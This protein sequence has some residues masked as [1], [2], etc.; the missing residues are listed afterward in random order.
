[1][2]IAERGGGKDAKR[3]NPMHKQPVY[4]GADVY[5][6]D[7]EVELFKVGMCLP[8]GPCVSDEDVEYIVKCIKKAMEG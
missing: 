7:I 3:L 1:M 6:N 2:S 8:S 4:A 5:T